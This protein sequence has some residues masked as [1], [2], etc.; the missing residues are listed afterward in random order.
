MMRCVTSTCVDRS[1]VHDEMCNFYLCCTGRQCMMR[2]VT[3]TCVDRSTV[4]DEMCNFY[5]CPQVD[6]A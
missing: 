5:L 3:S 4:H 6:S 2:C 1:T